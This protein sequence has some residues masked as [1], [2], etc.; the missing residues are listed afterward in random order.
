MLPELLA[1]FII[2]GVLVL[3]VVETLVE[4]ADRDVRTLPLRFKWSLAWYGLRYTLILA[5]VILCAMTME[6]R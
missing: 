3:V 5:T 1:R 4:I 2:A 6:N